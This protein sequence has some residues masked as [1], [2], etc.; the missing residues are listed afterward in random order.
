[1]KPNTEAILL[2]MVVIITFFA[3]S[4][5]CRN[6]SSATPHTPVPTVVDPGLA[7]GIPCKPPCWQGLTPGEST[8]Q[9][10]ERVMG[11]LR[12]SE[13]VD[14]VQDN[15]P[16]QYEVHLS[17]FTIYGATHVTMDVDTGMVTRIYGPTL[18]YHPVGTLVEQFGGPEWLWTYQSEWCSSCEE[19]E[20]PDEPTMSLSAHLLYPSQG[21]WFLVRVP[22]SGVGCICP[23][24]EVAA[25]CYYAPITLQEALTDDYLAGLCSSSLE[26]VAQDD[27]VE[28]HGFGGGY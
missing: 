1:M 21:L 23:E 26:G 5:V 15:R 12:D 14:H 24:M 19:W 8:S 2:V 18:F 20:P 13:W 28:W 22:E 3:T 25:F 9:E 4:C 17:P 6:G 10:V 7:Y 11:Q 16:W 27:L